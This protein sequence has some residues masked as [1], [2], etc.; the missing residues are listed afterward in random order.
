MADEDAFSLDSGILRVNR[1][2]DEVEPEKL[3]EVLDQLV[4]AADAPVLDLAGI[5]YV[6][7]RNVADIQAAADRCLHSGRSLTIRSRRNVATMLERM[8][9]GA[10]ARVKAVQPSDEASEA[11]G[12]E[13]RDPSS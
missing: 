5:S 11:S 6:P 13:K 10:V 12:K 7:S 2:L 8:G 1:E 3:Q 4:K 9:L